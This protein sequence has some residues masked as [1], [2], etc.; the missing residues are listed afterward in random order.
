MTIPLA[1]YP[2]RVQTYKYPDGVGESKKIWEYLK[3]LQGSLQ[4]DAALRITDYK[5][6]AA[7]ADTNN[8]GNI[9]KIP[10]DDTKF[11]SGKLTWL[12]AGGSGP[13]NILS[14]THSDTTVSTPNSGD[15]L[16]YSTGKWVA[17]APT[18]GSGTYTNVVDYGAK[19]DGTTDDTSAIA[20]A[21]A[22]Q[23]ALGGGVVYFPPGT[24]RVIPYANPI[25]GG[26][27]NAGIWVPGDITIMGSGPGATTIKL[28]D[29][30]I[31]HSAIIENYN[32]LGGYPAQPL[33]MNVSVKD[34]GVDGNNTNQGGNGSNKGIVFVRVRFGTVDNVVVDNVLGTSSSG[35]NEG[36][37]MYPQLSTD[38]SYINCVARGTAGNREIGFGGNNS[39]N[40]KFVNC[41]SYGMSCVGGTVGTGFNIY[42]C[43]Q[44]EYVNCHSFLN[45][46][47]GFGCENSKNVS[48]S[49]CMAGGESSDVGI[50]PNDI[51][52]S[53]AVGTNFGNGNYGHV[54][55]L[56]SSYVTISGGVISNNPIG[57]ILA[58]TPDHIT[59]VG[60]DARNNATPL[61]GTA[62]NLTVMASPG[63]DSSPGDWVSFSPS[64]TN[65]TVGAGG[66]LTGYYMQIGKLVYFRVYFKYG[67]GSAVSGTMALTLPVTAASYGSSTSIG[68]IYVVDASAGAVFFGRV[69]SSGTMFVDN[70]AGTYAT[71][72]YISST[73][74]M[75][76][77]TDDYFTIQGS[78]EALA[79]IDA[80][81]TL[82]G[83]VPIGGIIM[84]SG[85]I[86]TI[87]TTW[88]LCDGT[89]NAPGPDLRD[90]FVV[91][92]SSDDAGVAKSNIEGA[93]HQT[94]GVTGHLHST[95]AGLTHTNASIAAHPSFTSGMTIG[96]HPDLTHAAISI[97]P[98]S[99]VVPQFT[100]VV[101]SHSCVVPS[102]SYPIPSTTA[103]WNMGSGTTA[104][105][106]ATVPSFN[107]VMPSFSAIVPSHSNIVPSFNAVV[108]S[109]SAVVPSWSLNNAVMS[110]GTGASASVPTQ[111]TL[112]TL[113]ATKTTQNATCT[114]LGATVTTLGATVTTQNATCTTLAATGT[115]S[116]TVGIPA[117]NATQT[118]LGATVT[119]LGATQA[120]L[121]APV[122]SATAAGGGT[123]QSTSY[124]THAYTVGSLT[125]S[126]TEPDAHT[127][128]AH[129]T[130]SSLSPYFALCLIQRMS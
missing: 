10:N 63:I 8:S 111:V 17:A 56:G 120:S 119:T 7:I 115:L 20:S 45:V 75:T 106:T 64:I 35:A 109:F 29:N 14:V 85:S 98:A 62:T 38:I 53:Y 128:S 43:S 114:T 12:A 82:V 117:H 71:Y 18:G 39:S 97:P 74:P 112:T 100:A 69:Q 108:P 19:G 94:G 123:H 15:V 4:Q 113:G 118:T 48:Y 24:Y 122:A 34:L 103:S 66:T 33:D 125:H 3:I 93:L 90:K 30:A 81:G 84:W 91:C 36:C 9:P 127:I 50:T 102:G 101:P 41:V 21:I 99:A 78:Y 92:A 77:A 42:G 129:D 55:S 13:H 1:P 57:I 27:Y 104:G 73:V 22:A 51:G 23:V 59:I 76:W 124:G 72:S 54:I 126:F 11:L 65:L 31:D 49:G 68:S 79:G 44:V 47:D 96:A 46:S 121:N 105:Y 95:H 130:V 70:V 26:S 80:W 25:S 60:V 37:F 107:A 52:T 61:S 58:N 40:I 2:V 67:A 5:L 89:A 86:A 83:N 32:L 88:A 28:C 116:T 110:Q 87:P 16:T 6:L